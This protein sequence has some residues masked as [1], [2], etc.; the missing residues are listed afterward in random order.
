MKLILTHSIKKRELEPYIK[1]FSLEV[2]KAAARKS[3]EGL[4]DE[5]KCSTKIPFTCLKKLYLTSSG[6]AGRVI[7]LLQ[8][9]DKKS[10]LVLLRPK[11]DKQIGANMTIKNPKFKRALDRNL[12]LILK[13]LKNGDFEEFDLLLK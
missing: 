6:G 5:I 11:N 8:I 9:S 7:F 12:D 10:V 2:V 1:I 4:G 3:L 13:D